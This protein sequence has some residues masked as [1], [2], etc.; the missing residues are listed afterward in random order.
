MLR[1][2][3]V[4]TAAAG[5][6]AFMPLPALVSVGP[7]CA[8][9]AVSSLCMA[10][11]DARPES[12][13]KSK[14]LAAASALF[15]SSAAAPQG[16]QAITAGLDQAQGVCYDDSALRNR[17]HIDDGGAPVIL[18]GSPPIATAVAPAPTKIDPVLGVFKD[19]LGAAKDIPTKVK[20]LSSQEMPDKKKVALAAT[21]VSAV[22]LAWTASDKGLK[23]R[24]GMT[25]APK[26][27]VS[28]RITPKTETKEPE[29][30]PAQI[31]LR[32]KKEEMM[33]A[34][35]SSTYG[36]GTV[37][38]RASATLQGTLT[39]TRD[40]QK[41]MTDSQPGPSGSMTIGSRPE[42]M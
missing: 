7:A 25:P 36:S 32:M 9:G 21:V 16:T 20:D 28:L 1:P 3:L 12:G 17:L 10:S 31:L 26:K 24:Q 22:G 41:L 15:I 35:R 18:R 37:G 30:S 13:A 11:G 8:R 23:E 6:C 38:M 14:A 39:R 33:Q 34:K 4:A 27:T 29:E 42:G 40:V 5:S 19:L 2:V